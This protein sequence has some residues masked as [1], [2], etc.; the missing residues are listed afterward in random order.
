M[1]SQINVSIEFEQ[2]FCLKIFIEFVLIGDL[3]DL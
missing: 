3:R 1:Q 2:S